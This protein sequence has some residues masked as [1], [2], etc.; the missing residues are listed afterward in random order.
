MNHLA[1]AVLT[2]ITAVLIAM[3]PVTPSFGEEPNSLS[4]VERPDQLLI[5]SGDRPVA[6]YTFRHPQIP[7]PFFVD[8]HAPTGER[9]TRRFP[10][11]A[12]EEATDHDLL[13]PGLWLAFGDLGGVDFWRNQGRVEHVEFI[14]KPHVDHQQLVFVVRNRY[15][16]ENELVCFEDC[17]YTISIQPAGYR[18]TCDSLFSNADKPFTFGDQ[19]EM[20]LG[21]RLT[22]PLCVKGG[23]GR[24]LNSEGLENESQI[25]GKPSRWCDIS[26]NLGQHRVGITLMTHPGNFGPS[27]FHARDYGLCVANP[28]GRKAFTGREASQVTVPSGQSLRLRF[29][30]LLHGDATAT[31]FDPAAAYEGYVA[32]SRDETDK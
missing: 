5:H 8:L 19:E 15:Q 27:W 1:N 18:I 13:H 17:R 10:P 25:W 30:V 21:V 32:S 26:G 3:A 14:E 24:M 22:A 7:R 9:V 2:V 6:T 23:S 11:V 4:V 12:G 29:G 16:K 28:F 31:S 20:G